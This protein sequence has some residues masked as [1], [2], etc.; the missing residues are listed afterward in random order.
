LS[1]LLTDDDTMR[2][3]NRRY[4]G[5]DAATD[6]LAFPQPGEALLGDVAISVETAQRQAARRRHSLDREL[7]ILLVHGILHLLGW[8]DTTAQQR[9]RMLKR[10]DEVLDSL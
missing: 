9:R 4:R 7:E 8:D 10:G 1:V 5:V 2:D 6:V 3:L